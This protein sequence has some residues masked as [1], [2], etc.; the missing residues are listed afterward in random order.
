MIAWNEVLQY[1]HDLHINHRR[2]YSE[3]NGFQVAIQDGIKTD[4]YLLVVLLC[5]VIAQ[6]RLQ[7]E[8]GQLL[9]A[10]AEEGELKG[11][12]NRR[13]RYKKKKLGNCRRL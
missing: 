1:I 11:D 4:A 3:S 13:Q 12:L 5:P 9:S 7:G 10:T 8:V 2:T 6:R